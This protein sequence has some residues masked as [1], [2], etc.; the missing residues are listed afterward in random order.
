[1]IAECIIQYQ[2]VL[3]IV[4]Y[5]VFPSERIHSILRYSSEISFH[6]LNVIR[7]F[8]GLTIFLRFLRLGHSS[9]ETTLRDKS[10]TNVY[11]V[12]HDQRYSEIYD[13]G[14]LSYSIKSPQ[15]GIRETV[16]FTSVES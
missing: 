1:M 9:C 10:F 8:I 14:L 13:E 2:G 6:S 3:S 16:F 7:A 5:G 4:V 11:H 12:A 15:P